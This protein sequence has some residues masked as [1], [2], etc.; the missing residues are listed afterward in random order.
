[1]SGT[2]NSANTVS[3]TTFAATSADPDSLLTTAS[4]DA[5]LANSNVLVTTSNSNG[6]DVGNITVV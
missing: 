1:M 4:L 2:N 5:A 3:G 6:A